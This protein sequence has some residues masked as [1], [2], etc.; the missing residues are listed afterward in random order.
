MLNPK[1]HWCTF[2]HVVTTCEI[3][4]KVRLLDMLESPRAISVLILQWSLDTKWFAATLYVSILTN[5]MNIHRAS[6]S[7]LTYSTA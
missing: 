1:A 7:M 2:I 4:M 3:L 6:S 5:Y